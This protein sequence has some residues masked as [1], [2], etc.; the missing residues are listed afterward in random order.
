MMLEKLIGTAEPATTSGPRIA[1]GRHRAGRWLPKACTAAADCVAILLAAGLAMMLATAI[2]GQELFAAHEH[3]L[4][5]VF[6]LPLWILMFVRYGLYRTR[7]VTVPLEEFRRIVHAVAASILALAAVGFLLKLSVARSWLLLFFATAVAVVSGERRL[8]RA[9]FATLRRRGLLLRPVVIVGG[10]AEGIA[11]TSVLVN[12]PAL[13]YRVLGFVDDTAPIGSYLLDHKPVLGGVDEVVDVVRRCNA[14]C[15]LVATSA[16]DM[17]VTNRLARQ[18]NQ[19]GYY[20]ELSLSLRGIAADRLAVRDLGL[21]QVASIAPVQRSGWRGMAKRALDVIGA[22]IGLLFLAPVLA[23][24]GLAIRLD[25]NGPVLFRQQRVGRN[26]KPF[27]MLKFRTMVCNAEELMADLRMRNEVNGP[28]FKLKDDPRVTRVG[29]ILRRLS[30]DELPQLWNVLRGEM[31][32][33][34]PRPALPHEVTG[35][36]PQL[37]Q[38][39]MVKPGITGMWQVNG[40]SN[41]SFEDYERLD[42]YYVDNWSLLTDLAIVAKTVVA[43]LRRQG[44]Y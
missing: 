26:G 8:V 12:N 40:R 29:R 7:H 23:L 13:G 9:V 22:T 3:V 21:F 33:V 32:L 39:L 19:A 18:L 15:A 17:E 38:R 30:L 37:H 14:A 11:L 27:Q 31:S 10:N 16:V 4:L 6:S 35:W 28:L 36:T 34:G 2:R 20:A 25:S 41:A 1:G 42:L 43:V 5:T 44:A 24:I